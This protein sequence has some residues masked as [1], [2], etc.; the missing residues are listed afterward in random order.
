MKQKYKLETITPVH[1]GSGETLNHIDGYYADR[2]WY[3]IDLDK[4]L[5]HPNTDINGLTSEMSQRDFRWSN[6]F[7]RHNMNAADLSTYSLLCAHSPGTT[8]IR[9][10]IKSVGNRPYIPG[11]SIKGAIRTALLSDLINHKEN[12]RLFD[13]S[14]AHLNKEIGK[15]SRAYRRNETPAKRIE[16]MALGKDPNHDLLR[17]LQVSDTEPLE[18]DA[19]AIETAWTVT[20]NQN[21]QLEQ[22]IE[23]NTEYKNY[24]EVI[25][26]G[27][28]LTF[29]LKI[30]DWLFDDPAYDKLGFNDTQYG[31]IQSIFDV[32]YWRN[33]ALIDKEIE[34]YDSHNFVTLYN[35]YIGLKNR[36]NSI[37]DGA[38]MLQIGWGTGYLVN[39]VSSSFTQGEDAPIDLMALRERYRLGTSRSRRGH[40]DEREFPKTRR[41]L[42]RGENPIAPLG[43]VKISP[44]QN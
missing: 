14:S 27:Q 6:Y 5:T 40:Y 12:Q 44:V 34:F 42:Y 32:C 17:A 1:I 36:N 41:I 30:D 19:L 23:G 26:G 7:S 4:V 21:N 25:Q 24:V 29:T 10:A 11:S 33:N 43:W 2:K 31:A 9:E 37:E 3:R 22:K 16:E 28:S 39:T 18:S 38:F 8:D 35:R 13:N 15:G 20:L